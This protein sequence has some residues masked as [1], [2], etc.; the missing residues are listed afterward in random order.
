[1]VVKVLKVEEPAKPF[2]ALPEEGIA[3]DLS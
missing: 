2:P 1:M 3:F